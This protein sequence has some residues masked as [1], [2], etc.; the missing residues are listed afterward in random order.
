MSKNSVGLI[1]L[2][3]ISIAGLGL[4]GYT[5]LVTQIFVQPEESEPRLVGIWDA[6]DSNYNYPPHTLTTDWLFQL[7]ANS[8]IDLNFVSVINSGTRV[9]LLKPGWYR[10]HISALLQSLDAPYIYRIDLLKNGVLLFNFDFVQT[11][12]GIYEPY[13]RT[14]QAEGYVLSDGNDYI[15]IN[16]YS[17]GD[18]FLIYDI[19]QDSNQLVIN[20]VSN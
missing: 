2:G 12:T 13:W 17:N 9:T 3:L 4:G 1:I 6:L 19:L 15:E 16:G 8:Y 10:I 5:F 7:S 18:V 14:I 20:F 11:Y